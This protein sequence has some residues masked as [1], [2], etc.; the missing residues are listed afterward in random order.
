[1]PVIRAPLIVVAA[2][3]SLATLL[4]TPASAMAAPPEAIEL[5]RAV[6]ERAAGTD[7]AALE[8][9]GLEALERGDREGLNRLY[10][11]TWTVLNQGDFD[12]ATLWN[13]RLLSHARQQ[14]DERYTAIARLNALTIRY[15]QGDLSVITEMDRTARTSNDWFV[16][17]H[18]ARLSALALMDQDR[19]GEGLRL[20]TMVETEIPVDAPFASTAR[21][22]PLSGRMSSARKARSSI[23]AS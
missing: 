17:A 13:N 12:K 20:L 18:A 4:A 15:D 7:F 11:V 22:T 21:A 1:M 14:R 5:A 19:V 16:K 10:H 8:A 3:A 9:F 23:M 2:L 6:E